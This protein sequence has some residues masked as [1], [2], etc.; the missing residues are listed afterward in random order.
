MPPPFS[1]PD[2]AELLDWCDKL[3]ETC[4]RTGMKYM[5]GETTYYRPNAMFWRRKAREGAFGD[6][7]YAELPCSK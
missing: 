5:L 3:V 4:R 6:F 2:D 7:I 1:G